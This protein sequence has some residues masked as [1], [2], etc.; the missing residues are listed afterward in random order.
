[1]HQALCWRNGRSSQMTILRTFIEK[2]STFDQVLEV[3]LPIYI[4]LLSGFYH[5]GQYGRL[6]PEQ[7]DIRDL[8][9]EFLNVLC[10]YSIRLCTQYT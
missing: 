5:P 8:A 4:D 2:I 6:Q 3:C 9:V 7:P 1:M 10:G